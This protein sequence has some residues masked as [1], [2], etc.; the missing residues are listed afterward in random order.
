[1]LLGEN[2]D[3]I[4]TCPLKQCRQADAIMN[5][6]SFPVRVAPELVF[7]VIEGDRFV[8]KAFGIQAKK[9]TRPNH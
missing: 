3:G 9:L 7:D 6:L 5:R 2:R 8:L 4:M 1:M